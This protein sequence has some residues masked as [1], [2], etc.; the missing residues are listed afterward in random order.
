MMFPCLQCK[1]LCVFTN[2]MPCLQCKNYPV[3]LVTGIDA[4]HHEASLNKWC[5]VTDIG[6]SMLCSSVVLLDIQ[7]P[8]F[9]NCV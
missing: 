9:L 2:N 1:L 6:N 8:F 3:C 7:F 4:K 5:G